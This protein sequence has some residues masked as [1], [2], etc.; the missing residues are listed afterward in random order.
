MYI[1]FISVLKEEINKNNG[2][3]EVIST[4]ITG[5]VGVEAW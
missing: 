1:I 3:F 2:R 4:P 5:L